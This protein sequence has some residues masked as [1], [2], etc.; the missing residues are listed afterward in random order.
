MTFT[1]ACEWHRH[2]DQHERPYKCREQSCQQLLGFTYLG[3][4]LRH[5]REVHKEN[6]GMKNYLTRILYC[7]FQNCDRNTSS[8]HGFT[9]QENL[10]DHIR[11]RHP[12]KEL[13]KVLNLRGQTTSRTRVRQL[14]AALQ[15]RDKRIAVQEQLIQSLESLVDTLQQEKSVFEAAAS[16][17]AMT[18]F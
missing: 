6:M 11:R 13:P 3:G 12:N 1:R 16:L 17:C 9:R 18:L 4:L 5:N 10:N 8:G 14:Q 2:M 7:P 15:Q